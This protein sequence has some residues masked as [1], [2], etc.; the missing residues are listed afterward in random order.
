MSARGHGCTGEAAKGTSPSVVGKCGQER[1]CEKGLRDGCGRQEWRVPG[2]TCEVEEVGGEAGS[3][4]R[5]LGPS[6]SRSSFLA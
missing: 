1:A 5:K 3:L 6:S 4:E 2:R